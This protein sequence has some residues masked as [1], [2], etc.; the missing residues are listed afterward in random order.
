M[1]RTI[2]VY[3]FL[4]TATPRV[5]VAATE[6]PTFTVVQSYD[7]WELRQYAPTLEAQ[8]EVRGVFRSAVSQG[9]RL[10]A[11]FIFGNNV[12]PTGNGAQ[13]I[14]MTAPVSAAPRLQAGT[15][16]DDGARW[17]VTFTMPSEFTVASLP[18][19][20]NPRVTIHKNKGG[21]YAAIRFKGKIKSPGTWEGMEDTLRKAVKEQGLSAA[22]TVRTAQYDGPWVPGPFRRN[23]LLLPVR[24]LAADD[25]RCSGTAP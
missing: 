6:E 22:G 20:V 23:E 8:V 19:P 17:V 13:K 25:P 16:S 1:W 2:V 24:C 3:F 11:D 15:P 4:I 10:L 21:L 5:S 9:F 14:A 18:K 7:Q 12:S